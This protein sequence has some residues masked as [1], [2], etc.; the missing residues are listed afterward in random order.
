M[1]S[2][3]LKYYRLKNAMSKKELAEQVSVSPMAISN[4]ENGKRKPDMDLL[5]RMAMILGV[6]VSD[7]LAI[8]DEKLV[9]YHGEL[10]KN[11]TLSVAQQDYVRE[12]VEEYFNRF[13]TIVE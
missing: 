9:F 4:Y 11:S 1:F 8:R 3:N 13:M 12:S 7:F 10:R 5:K 6:R 2:K